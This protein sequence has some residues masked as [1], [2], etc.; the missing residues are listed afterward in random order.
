M[1]IWILT[2]VLFASLA[3]LGYRQGA[4][5][6]G[7]SFFGILLGALLAMPLGRLIEPLFPKMGLDNPLILL[8]VPPLIVFLVFLI[9]FKVAGAFVHR[10]VEVFY[11]YR[12]GDLRL[13]LWERLHRRVGLCLAM[14]NGALYLILIAWVV[15]VVS[16]WTYQL[17]T[18]NDSWKLNLLNRLGRDLHATGLAKVGA[19]VDR[20]PESY[21]DLADAAGLV[22]QTPELDRRRLPR[23]PALFAIAQRP[24]FQALGSDEGFTSLRRE[25]RPVTELLQN[26]TA[27]SILKSPDALNAVYQALVPNVQDFTNFLATGR[28]PKF[29]KQPLLG[30]WI[31]D[32]S[33]SV[34]LLR[35]ERP[36]I[37]ATQLSQARRAMTIAFSQTVLIAAPEGQVFI[38]NFPGAQAMGPGAETIEGKWT[39]AGAHYTFTLTI[40]GRTE[41]FSVALDG[42]RLTISGPSVNWA[43]SRLP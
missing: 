16:Y 11:K 1:T 21:Y 40:G 36:T 33:G 20:T 19:A 10:K 18:P 23:Y 7:F 35:K 41:N 37:T 27:D 32:V 25:L 43:F 30:H 34:G 39:G 15:F 38:N 8:S 22:F 24:E 29:E 13:A 9:L 6:V 31:F 5:R 4:I 14:C 42:D 12:A 28:S 3:G 2:L 17:S 26:P